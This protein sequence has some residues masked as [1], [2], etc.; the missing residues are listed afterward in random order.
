MAN[1]LTFKTPVDFNGNTIT[2]LIKEITIAASQIVKAGQ[3]TGSGHAYLTLSTTP[4]QQAILENLDN[5]I[6]KIDL[7]EVQSLLHLPVPY[8]WIKRNTINVL[9]GLTLI[10]YSFDNSGFEYEHALTDNY[11]VL[12]EIGTGGAIYES[13]SSKELFIS[14]ASVNPTIM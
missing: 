9:Q 4:E 1:K 13:T 12:K 7:S 2:N 8:L 5:G 14:F 11:I 6:I 3:D 10:Q